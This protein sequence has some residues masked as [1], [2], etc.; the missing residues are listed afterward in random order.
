MKKSG[1]RPKLAR[2]VPIGA[3]IVCLSG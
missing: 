3:E 2:E 1:A